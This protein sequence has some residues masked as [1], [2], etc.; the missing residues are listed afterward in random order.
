MGPLQTG[1]FLWKARLV[2]INA[3]VFAGVYGL[4]ELSYST[5]SYFFRDAS[6]FSYLVIEHPGETVRFDADR[7]FFLTETPSRMARITLGR[8]EYVGPFHGNA[9]GFADR[10]DFSVQRRKPGEVRIGVFGD[11]FTAATFEPSGFPNWPA[12]AEDVGR[13]KGES[14][15]LLNFGVDG[16]GLAN[17]ASIMRNIVIKDRYDLDGLIFAIAWD[18]LYRKFAMFEQTD[19]KTFAYAQAPSWDVNTQPR[20]EAEADALL[21]KHP[22]RNHYVLSPAQFDAAVSGKW[23]PRQW[24]FRITDRLIGLAERFAGHGDAPWQA[25][26]HFEPD[27]LALMRQI[28][29]LAEQNN[30]PIIVV[31]IPFRDELTVPG[32]PSSV[33]KTR[34]FAEVLG[35]KFIDGREAFRGV[36][37]QQMRELWFPYDGHWNHLG[38]SRFAEYMIA[39]IST[40]ASLKS[41]LA[42]AGGSQQANRPVAV[43]RP[44]AMAADQGLSLHHAHRSSIAR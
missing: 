21:R 14:L 40:W 42:T 34:Q 10:D 12:R 8:V 16:G 3:L 7:G 2:L 41:R 28:R 39:Q 29:S 32:Y 18:D 33:D 25:P 31:Y 17:W 43:S 19:P 20:T 37:A 13:L 1:S 22:M 26:T 5:Y 36:S 35:A 44:S 30:L 4:L 27:Q 9:Q 23:R 38:S 6:P 15:T 24:R 11:S